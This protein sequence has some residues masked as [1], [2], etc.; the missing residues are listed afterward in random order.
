MC[1]CFETGTPK[2]YSIQQVNTNGTDTKESDQTYSISF[3]QSTI[4]SEL[5]R[6]VIA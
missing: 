1:L 4:S 6:L 5:A 2:Q 3:G